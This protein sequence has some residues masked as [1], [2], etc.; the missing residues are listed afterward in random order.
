MKTRI[1]LFAFSKEIKD[2]NKNKRH[3]QEPNGNARP[4]N[5]VNQHEEANERAQLQQ[6]GQRKELLYRKC[7]I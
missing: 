5:S 2:I 3:K 7:T 1:R 4:E 6:G